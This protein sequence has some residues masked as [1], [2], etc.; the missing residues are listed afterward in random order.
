VLQRATLMNQARS[1][2]VLAAMGIVL[3]PCAG[4]VAAV[5]V[6]HAGHADIGV[7]YLTDPPRL[8]LKIRFDGNSQFEDGT[9]HSFERVT[10]ETVA[11][12]APDPPILRELKIDEQSMEV[13]YDLTGPEWDFLG[14]DPDEPLWFMPQTNDPTKPF[15]G[16]A[17][18]TLNI[19]HWSGPM[20]WSLD[21]VLSAPLGGN[22]SLWQT[23][24]GGEP[25]A[26]FAS[27]DGID[28]EL[29]SFTQPIG[30][31][32][33]YNW[34]FSKP[35][36]YKVQLGASA[37]RVGLGPVQ[38]SA[39]FTFLVGDDAIPPLAGDYNGD[40]MVDSVD[41]TVWRNAL[42]ATGPGLPAD[43]NNDHEVDAADYGVWKT[44]YGSVLSPP[45]VFAAAVAVPEPSVLSLLI[46][47]VI[48]AL[49]GA[50]NRSC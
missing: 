20:T 13:L 9:V 45:I 21:A 4:G 47:L 15:F 28:T 38:G 40:G 39:V 22:I 24:F 35:G 41:Y 11:I 46:G 12:R 3:G 48:V 37:T 10:P 30:G 23:G 44:N 50:I 31:H 5:P 49:R 36:V 7:D 26:K 27:F 43:G 29:D 19:P 16:F 1:F 42:G 33:H 6:Y 25:T 2:H 17:T 34:G 8:D 14:V 18:D 32:D